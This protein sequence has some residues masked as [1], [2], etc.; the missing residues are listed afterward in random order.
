[1]VYKELIIEDASDD[2]GEEMGSGREFGNEEEPVNMPHH[3]HN[4]GWDDNGGGSGR[5]P[6]QRTLDQQ[7]AFLQGQLQAI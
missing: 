1:M 7:E 6:V 5:G 4:D 2:D 3:R